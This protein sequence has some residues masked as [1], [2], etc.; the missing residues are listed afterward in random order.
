MNIIN[1]NIRFT[2]AGFDGFVLGDQ[3]H[4]HGMTAQISAIENPD[5]KLRIL[6]AIAKADRENNTKQLLSAVN[7]GKTPKEVQFNIREHR[8]TRREAGLY[9][10]TPKVV[11][12]AKVQKIF[13]ECSR[14]KNEAMRNMIFD[15]LFSGL[16]NADDSNVDSRDASVAA[17]FTKDEFWELMFF[18]SASGVLCDRTDH[19]RIRTWLA[20]RGISA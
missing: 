20:R 12:S 10:V 9:A 1:S 8:A 7:F 3:V 15:V 13:R 6:N 18:S 5:F 14:L 11:P 2:F 4:W 17:K 19:K 16:D